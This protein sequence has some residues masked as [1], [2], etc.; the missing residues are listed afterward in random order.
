MSRAPV[1]PAPGGAPREAGQTGAAD[2][3]N[4]RRVVVIGG[5][6]AGLHAVKALRREPVDVLL[7]D[8]TN[9][10]L[11]QPLLY[12]VATAGLSPGDIARPLRAIFRRQSNVTVLMAEVVAIDVERRVV[13]L[14]RG[15]RIP[16]D[17]LIVAVGARHSYFGHPEWE[18]RAPGL[19]TLDD[20]LQIREKVLLSFERAERAAAR[21]ERVDLRDLTFVVVGGGPTGVEMAGAIAEIAHQTLRRNFRLIDPTATRVHLVEGETAVLPTFPAELRASARRQLE[22]LRIDV[23]LDSLVVGVDEEGVTLEP[24]SQQADGETQRIATRNVVWAAGNQV[25]P[26]LAQLPGERDRAGRSTVG[27]DLSLPQRPEI[28]V[29]GDAA[30]FVG[31]DGAP[32]PA[33]APVAMQQGRHAARCVRAD[34]RALPRPPFRYR[35]RGT[36]ATIGK[37][38]AVAWI[39]RLRFGGL[40]AWLAWSLVHV[41][42]L[43]GFR[44][45]VSVM[46]EWIYLYL[47]GQRGARLLYGRSIRRIDE[48]G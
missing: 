34:L 39:H 1:D 14:H 16:Y 12:Q 25:S 8:R 10:H 17:W 15:E 2:I 20:A 30:R 28:F 19:K 9:H 22:E 44:N 35:D 29:V 45:R 36:M 4:R 21:G 33:L 38:R 40:L 42:F 7:V 13:E 5:G 18:A 43:I 41:T 48:G 37:A 26:L 11:F 27:E 6:F 47:T 31:E 3:R 46:L 32:L 24:A 23:R